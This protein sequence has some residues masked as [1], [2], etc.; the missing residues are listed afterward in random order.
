MTEPPPSATRLRLDE[1]IVARGLLPTR[2]RARD[3]VL[4]GSVKVDGVTAARPG[5]AVAET[6]AITLDDPAAEYVSRGALKLVAALDAFGFDPAGR[7]CL[8]LGASTGG[9][10]EV[11]LRRGAAFVFAV[12]VGHGQ[13]HP[14]LAADPRVRSMEGVNA[15]D[16][17]ASSFGRPVEAVVADLSFIS[18]TL[19]LPPALSL[20]APGA[21]LVALIKPQFE[22]GKAAIGKGGI[23]RDPIATETAIERIVL[24]IGRQDGWSVEGVIPSPLKGG[25]GN[26]EFLLG[27]RKTSS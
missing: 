17:D 7:V 19:A 11:L 23:V 4:R 26:A 14:S 20:A 21:W 27:A 18:L 24:W 16:L 12:D 6:S 25:D 5:A 15:R 13:L 3:A 9:F 1:A 2:S 8:D 10:T 22:V